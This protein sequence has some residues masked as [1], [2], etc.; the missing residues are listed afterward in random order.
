M[1]KLRIKNISIVMFFSIIWFFFDFFTKIWASGSS[2]KE[3]TFIKNF[4]YFTYQENTGIAFGIP[5]PKIIQISLSVIILI[6]LIYYSIK[7]FFENNRFLYLK[8]F[9]LGI[10]FGG[11]IGNGFDRLFKGYVVDFI[12]LYPIPVFNIADIGITLGLLIFSFLVITNTD[13]K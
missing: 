12:Y 4:F 8:L 13:K 11:A 6:G 5:L 1:K 3:F 9:L 7:Y 10:I 2:F